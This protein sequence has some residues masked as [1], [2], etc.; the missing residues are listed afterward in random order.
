MLML[1]DAWS[2]ENHRYSVMAFHAPPLSD[3]EATERG[4][5]AQQKKGERAARLPGA[6]LFP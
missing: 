2:F 1:R 5:P 4:V 6:P 3:M